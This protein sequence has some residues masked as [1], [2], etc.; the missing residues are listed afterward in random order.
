MAANDTES[1][2]RLTEFVN[3]VAT[4]FRLMIPGTHP[5]E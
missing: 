1:Q 2:L 3:D 4:V 5:C